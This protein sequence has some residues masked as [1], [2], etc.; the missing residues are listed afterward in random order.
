MISP[1]IKIKIKKYFSLNNFILAL[2]I[3]ATILLL[4]WHFQVGLMRYFD[5]DEF[6]HMFASSMMA[7]GQ[8][9]SRDFAYFYS[10][11][12]AALFSP[13]FFLLKE[14]ANVVFLARS[15]QFF[16]FCLSVLITGWIV[17][18]MS[19]KRA[20]VLAAFLMAFLPVALDKTL[21]VRLDVLSI[22]FWLL[23]FFLLQKKRPFWAGLAFGFSLV[24]IFKTAFA[25]PGLV[26]FLL[27]INRGSWKG[28]YQD[29]ILFHLGIILPLFGL[30]LSL[31][32]MGNFN[33]AVYEIII[34]RPELAAVYD[35][36]YFVPF[37]PF[38]QVD[39]FY[40]LGGRSLPWFLSNL[41]LALGLV[42]LFKSRLRVFLLVSF[43]SFAFS[44]LFVFLVTLVQYYLPLFYLAIIG[45]AE[46][47]NS[48]AGWLAKK[49]KPLYIVSW[50]LFLGIFSFGFWQSVKAHLNWNSIAQVE[51]IADTLAVS[52]P[53]DHFFD[54]MG[55]HLFRPSGYYLCCQ[56]YPDWI[57]NLSR[58]M[59][60]LQD[61]FRKK[62]TKFLFQTKRAVYW[63][64]DDSDGRFI[65]ENY[66]PSAITGI[67]VVGKKI[68][69]DSNQSVVFEIIVAGDYE[70]SEG[71]AAVLIDGKKV[72][73]KIFLTQGW[74][75]VQAFGAENLILTYDYEK[76]Q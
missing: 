32:L 13:L 64:L 68:V 50:A 74:H 9:P 33:Q 36:K 51:G 69:F 16:I 23:A 48:L 59:P 3:G 67:W 39:A 2:T 58:P 46:L 56:L 53:G 47:L 61:D 29:F 30:F 38:W 76:N 62:Q 8:T 42:G 57:N 14:N 10:P 34:S 60:R 37:Y 15:L 49:S 18:E 72:G 73:T 21:E 24:V 20:G 4:F 1:L 55:T 70:V 66:F 5:E 25:Y 52:R 12:Y 54:Y 26:I 22:V 17:K 40:G 19:G 71:K 45:A 75:Q 11:F 65:R 28:L 27:W 44:V 43:A 31:A 35:R 63:T 6:T 41:I 7:I